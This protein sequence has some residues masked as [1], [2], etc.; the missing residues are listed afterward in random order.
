[1]ATSQQQL[2]LRRPLSRKRLWQ[3]RLLAS[4][5]ALGL[6]CLI[7]ELGLRLLGY[8][9]A[10]LNPLEIFHVPDAVVA[11]RG[12]PNFS[13]IF[14]RP[15]FRVLVEHDAEGFRKHLTHSPGKPAGHIY[16]FGDSFTWGWGVG[17][18]EVYTDILA[19]ELPDREVHNL[20]LNASGTVQ[21]FRLFE[22]LVAPKLKTGDIVLVA[23]FQNDFRDNTTGFI[24]TQIN[25]GELVSGPVKPVGQSWLTSIKRS[26]YLVNLINYTIST[27]RLAR[28]QQRQEAETDKQVAL[29]AD[30][31][32]CQVLAA[33]L[34]KFREAVESRGATFRAVY[35]SHQYDLDELPEAARKT[36]TNPPYRQRFLESAAAA[37]VTPIDLTPAF[38]AAKQATPG[39][40]VSWPQDGHWTADGQRIA[41]QTL[42]GVLRETVFSGTTRTESVLVS[43][44]TS[45]QSAP[46]PQ[47]AQP[48]A[49]PGGKA[50][51]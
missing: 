2:S 36:A 47:L 27:R 22:Q 40:R 3:F 30:S 5:L 46:V 48:L 39:L 41:G 25:D 20:G 23:C 6:V 29:G 28:K 31:L 14:Q 35:V 7:C 9:P 42:A 24:P 51:R 49:A 44:P 43:K 4:G 17:P 8:N 33:T 34:R 16:A 18:G 26:S 12:T 45:K 13:G 37:G 19:R 21:Q 50:F 1:M 11:Y 15:E 32:E 10:Y 38:L